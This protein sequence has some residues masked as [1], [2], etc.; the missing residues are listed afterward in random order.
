MS[1]ANGCFDLIDV[2]SSLAAGTKRVEL[3]ICRIDI[4]LDILDFRK[5]DDRCRRSVHS[6]LGFR[7]GHSLNPVHAALELQH[8]IDVFPLNR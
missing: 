1:D 8:P 7:L 3:K 5:D 6:S 4:H 2:L